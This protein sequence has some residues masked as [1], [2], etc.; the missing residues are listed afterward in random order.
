MTILS[1]ETKLEIFDLD[2]SYLRKMVFEYDADAHLAVLHNFT[3]IPIEQYALIEKITKFAKGISISMDARKLLAIKESP[4]MH[5]GEEGY[6]EKIMKEEYLSLCGYGA[7]LDSMIEETKER[8]QNL[9]AASKGID[10]DELPEFKKWF[11][12]TFNILDS[13]ELQL[14]VMRETFNYAINSVKNELTKGNYFTQHKNNGDNI[15]DF[16]SD[17]DTF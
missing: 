14:E 6:D 4:G 11:S 1:L 10:M 12:E 8:K 17:N 13:Y 3:V 2:T 15:R 16:T 9:H 5:N 7:K